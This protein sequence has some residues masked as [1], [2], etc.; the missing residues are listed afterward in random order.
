[1]NP[2][3]TNSRTPLY[4]KKE[5]EEMKKL[6]APIVRRYSIYSF[7]SAPL[8]IFSAI[9]LYFLLFH[10]TWTSEIPLLI[11]YGVLGAIGLA[12][13][14]ESTFQSKQVFKMG[15]HYMINRMKESKYLYDYRKE[16]YLQLINQNPVDAVNIFREFLKEEERMRGN[17]VNKDTIT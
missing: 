2:F 8:V 4:I 14:K 13:F 1:M 3:A 10:S 6:T 11:I 15:Y 17:S 12:L 7:I 5:F 9:N 16:R